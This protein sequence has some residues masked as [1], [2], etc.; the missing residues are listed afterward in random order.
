MKKRTPQGVST[1]LILGVVAILVTVVVSLVSRAVVDI[2]IT[3]QQEEQARAF[4]VAEAGL[5]K[6]LVGG[7][8]EGVIEGIDYQVF[9]GQEIGNS[10]NYDYPRPVDQASPVTVWL[11]DHD[12]GDEFNPEAGLGSNSYRGN[13][14]DLY[15]GELAASPNEDTTPAIE[16]SLYYQDAGGNI[17]VEKY[18][19]DP[20]GSRPNPS[21]F[22]SV[23]TGGFPSGS[24]RYEF[25]HQISV[26]CTDNTCLALR[27]RLFFNDDRPHPLGVGGIG[28][29]IPSQG[30]CRQSTATAGDSGIT[31]RVQRC[32]F[33][34]DF[35]SVLDFVLYSSSGLEKD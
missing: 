1:V 17:K 11:V 5:E 30:E 6:A 15:W 21:G 32:V 8:D 2:R 27:L 12:D 9:E 25:H 16:A 18:T 28:S 34:K 14:I 31:S 10:L 26:P 3:K 13:S 35:P 19:A 23:E 24:A 7:P 29:N 22:N 20:N 33:Y 4:S